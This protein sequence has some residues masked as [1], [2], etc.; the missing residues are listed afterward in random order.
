MLRHFAPYLE[1]LDSVYR[2]K[3][4]LMGQKARL[5]AVITLL[6]L[7]FVP[8]NIAKLLWAQLPLPL[9]RIAINLFIG[10][11]SIACLR[12]VM[13]GKLERA[14][15]ALV[16]SMTL[17]IHISVF[18]VRT[19]HDPSL[20]LSI[21]IQIFAFDF[22]IL[23]FAIVFASRGIAASVFAI[24]VLGHI[25][26]Y[27]FILQKAHFDRAVQFSADTL[28][29]DGLLVMVLLFCLGVTLIHMIESAH[30]RSENSL[31]QTR[32]MNENLERLVSE[33]TREL[34][35]ASR[36]ATA[37]SRAKSEFLAN[38]S[39]EIRTPLNGII[40]SSD[41]LMRRA[42]LPPEA[43][44]YT[45]LISESGDLLLNLLGDIL[46]F[47]KIEAGQ[48][49]LEKH[50]FD[51]AGI[52]TNT[53]TLM[54]RQAAEKSVRLDV[55]I[56]PGLA[57]TFEGDSYRLRQVLLNLVS[58]AV[59]FSLPEGQ[60]QIAITAPSAG[61]DP[62]PILFE[63]RDTGIGMDESTTKRIFERFAQADSSTTRRYGGTGLGLAISS[64]I[65]QM[66]GGHLDVT[67]ALG[68][69]S[70]FFFTIPL[71]P[72]EKPAAGLVSPFQAAASPLNLRV[73]VAEDN[74]VNRKIIGSQ[75]AQLG[76]PFTMAV[77][78]EAALA[79]LQEEP[80]PDVIIMDCHMPKLDGWETTRRIRNWATSPHAF[81][82]RSATIP[83]IALTAAAYPEEKARCHDA[84][85]NA[86]VAKPVKLAELHEALLPYSRRDRDSA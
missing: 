53:V 6:L 85:M 25:S 62:M 57:R 17:V 29:R 33:R 12:S 46:D 50:P 7:A 1:R 4:F 80:L 82:K 36:Q 48:I 14:G 79:A 20:P 9:P 76:C 19:T 71:R 63:V 40:A 22:V 15:N 39:H 69:G 27:L 8:L 21:G 18:L 56:A 42:D 78:G 74:A 32:S 3:P 81:Q 26:I 58:N 70:A 61:A 86:F 75:L 16:L 5:L 49:A 83:V 24:I 37:A 13:R 47:S 34:E 72:V 30:R 84:G 28:L 45:R 51:L 67:S 73:L 43:R 64:R 55:T 23:L 77:D 35:Q 31:R 54:A 68:K 44:E 2:D 52:V 60:V 65:V 41:L 38:M 59:K 11:A 10:A 66:M